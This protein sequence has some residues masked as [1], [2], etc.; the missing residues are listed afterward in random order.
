MWV[1]THTHT[2]HGFNNPGVK[3]ARSLLYFQALAFIA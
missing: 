2:Q 3:H 1:D